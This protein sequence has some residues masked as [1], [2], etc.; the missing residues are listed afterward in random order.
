M[1]EQQAQNTAE[2]LSRLETL[3]D[4]KKHVYL[5]APFQ[6]HLPLAHPLANSQAGTV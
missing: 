1:T 3:F 2:L 4:K 5:H 6:P